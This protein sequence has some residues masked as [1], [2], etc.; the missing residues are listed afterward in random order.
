MAKGKIYTSKDN[1]YL[2]IQPSSPGTKVYPLECFDLEDLAQSNGGI[3]LIQCINEYGQYET[4]GA[5][6][7]P[8]E[9]VSTSLGTYLGEVAE[10]MEYVSCPFGL[11]VT[12]GCG[13]KGNFDSWE[14]AMLVDVRAVTNINYSGLVR[15][16]EDVPAMVTFDIEGSA[17][18]GRFYRL[19][20][21]P[22]SI[23]A[24]V[25]GNINSMKFSDDISCWSSCGETV[26]EC[27]KGIAVTVGGTAATANVLLSPEFGGTSDW[28]ATAADPFAVAEDIADGLIVKTGRNTDRIITV[29]GTT[30]AGNPM[31]IAWSDDNGATWNLVDVGSTDGEFA[32][33]KGALFALSSYDIYL[34]SN[35]GRIYKS[36]DGG[37]TW[38]VKEDANITTSAYNAIKMLNPNLGYAVGTSGLVVKTI[39]G[40]KTWGQTGAVAG[41][42]DLYSVEPI[43]SK[44]VI[45]GSTLGVSYET[46]N[47]GETWTATQ[48]LDATANVN[49]I[50]ALDQ[51]YIVIANGETVQFTIN[52]GFS[53]D[54]IDDTTNLHSSDMVSVNICSTRKVFS[55]STDAIVQS[56]Q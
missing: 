33:K 51:Y 37:L 2:Y 6:V 12:L 40:G 56:T 35:L 10:Y 3:T 23:D 41:S 18:I 48:H 43:S 52:G 49:D 8:P 15:K 31:E 16:E 44:R 7:A 25:T 11:Y 14:R 46:T 32:V 54:T 45:V 19:S 28:A 13:K 36:E 9:P 30:D 1:G 27:E 42:N 34:V 5:T 20:S 38:T 22:Q 4:L 21:A 50:Q 39:D 55:T 17:G 24:A 53:W 47:G 26:G 29:R